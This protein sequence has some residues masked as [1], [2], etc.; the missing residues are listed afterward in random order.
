MM[1][2]LII[3]MINNTSAWTVRQQI[4]LMMRIVHYGAST[5][6]MIQMMMAVVSS[7]I[8]MNVEATAVTP[9]Q[10]LL[11]PVQL[12]DVA[13]EL[14]GSR[15]RVLER[16]LELARSVHGVPGLQGFH[17]ASD[18]QIKAAPFAVVAPRM[19]TER[20]RV[21]AKDPTRVDGDGVQRQR[22]T[23]VSRMCYALG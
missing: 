6:T 5:Q 22:A 3:M 19:A 18:V 8:Q 13:I 2:N 16:Q 17:R 23:D 12:A 11:R 1:N 7:T 21:T 10:P 9:V 15:V 20:A 4:W 14:I